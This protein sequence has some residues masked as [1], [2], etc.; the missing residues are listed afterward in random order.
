MAWNLRRKYSLEEFSLL[1]AGLDPS[2]HKSISNA[3]YSNTPNTSEAETW[4]S[5]ILEAI[6]YKDFDSK[7][8]ELYIFNHEPEGL[9]TMRA[10]VEDLGRYD[11]IS[12]SG[13]TIDRKAL[14][15]WLI[16]KNVA[17][18]DFLSD[19]TAAPTDPEHPTQNES[20][21]RDLNEIQK[22]LAGQHEHQTVELALA[23]KAW[24]GVSGLCKKKLL[25]APSI[26]QEVVAWLEDN[27]PELNDSQK[28]RISMMINWDKGGGRPSSKSE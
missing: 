20:E 15:K 25:S 28:S 6:K 9:P 16:S 10:A 18:P 17:L 23:I 11:D 4:L 2:E 26:K 19:S 3:K 8:Y 5:L 7:D 22:L 1:M 27:T 21:N 14:Q 13:S 12:L 24:L